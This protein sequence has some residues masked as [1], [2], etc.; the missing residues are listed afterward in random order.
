MGL[1]GTV[2][3]A[4]VVLGTHTTVLWG[5]PTDYAVSRA[6][7]GQ[8]DLTG[9]WQA[10]QIAGIPTHGIKEAGQIFAVPTTLLDT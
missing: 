7:D 9:I 6:A 3:A 1:R 8:P 5:Q 4:L 10:L 2:C